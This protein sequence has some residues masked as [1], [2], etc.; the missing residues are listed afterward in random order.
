MEVRA[1]ARSYG[2]TDTMEWAHAARKCAYGHDP[3]AFGSSG[4]VCAGVVLSYLPQIARILTMRSSLGLS[5]WFLFL[6][7]T[8][9]ASTFLN[10]VTLQ[11]HVF[12]CCPRI[13]RI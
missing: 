5:P 13:V 4:V 2:A 3:L 7:A 9:S 10:V 6:G 11:W 8:S 1:D 12:E